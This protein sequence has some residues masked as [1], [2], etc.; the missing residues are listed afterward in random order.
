M[1]R[2]HKLGARWRRKAADE[3]DGYQFERVIR[4]LKCRGLT[5]AAIGKMYGVTRQAIQRRLRVKGPTKGKCER[6]GKYRSLLHGHHPT[7]RK[8]QAVRLCVR[9]HASEPN[10]KS[11]TKTA[12][13]K[14]KRAMA[15]IT[16]PCCH[17]KGSTTLSEAYDETLTVLRQLR[18][19]TCAEI[20]KALGYDDSVGTRI[21]KR[22]ARLEKWKLVHRT[23]Q[24]LPKGETDPRKR[25]WVFEVA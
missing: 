15:A 18:Q 8:N 16:C 5:Y 20:A 19:A 23:G 17:G 12:E 13:L 9:C 21:H 14:Y 22:I 11:L 1:K 10:R 24:K 4:N 6:C 25:A 2:R 3:L 7:Y